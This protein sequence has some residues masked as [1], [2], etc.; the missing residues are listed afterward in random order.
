MLLSKKLIEPSIL[1]KKVRAN[2]L[3]LGQFDW[4]LATGW[5]GMDWVGLGWAGLVS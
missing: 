5:L 1:S 3:N 2:L 4:A